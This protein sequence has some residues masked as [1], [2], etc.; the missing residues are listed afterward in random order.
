MSGFSAF[1]V[2][3]TTGNIFFRLMSK[4][5]ETASST[6]ECLS[7]VVGNSLAHK[8]RLMAA[9]KLHLNAA[10]GMPNILQWK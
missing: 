2:F 10:Y 8:L 1:F 9:V 7:L 4:Q 5:M 3:T 6:N